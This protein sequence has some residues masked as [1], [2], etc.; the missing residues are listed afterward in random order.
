[1]KMALSVKTKMKHFSFKLNLE[2][3]F[4]DLLDIVSIKGSFRIKARDLIIILGIEDHRRIT[5]LGILLSMLAKH[6]LA[7]RWN[8]ARPHRYS[9][10]PHALW[11]RFIEI[12]GNAKPRFQCERG[13]SLC[14]LYG[15]CPYTVLKEVMDN[16]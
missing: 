10:V 16:N 9:L 3:A 8:H 4:G 5:Q 2:Q 15:I 1:M 13:N 7:V 6:K 11:L 12:C 14:G